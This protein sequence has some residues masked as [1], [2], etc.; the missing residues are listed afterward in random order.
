MR[1]IGP[2]DVEEV[3]VAAGPGLIGREQPAHVLRM[4]FG[5]V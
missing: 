1:R 5:L 4:D 2:A 3:F